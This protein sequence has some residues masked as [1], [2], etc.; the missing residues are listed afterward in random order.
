MGL[1]VGAVAVGVV[2]FGIEPPN[3]GFDASLGLPDDASLDPGGIGLRTLIMVPSGFLTFTILKAFCESE[4]LTVGATFV[5]A[6]GLAVAG[7]SVA[8]LGVAGTAVVD[9]SEAFA[10]ASRAV[11]EEAILS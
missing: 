11:S 2:A 1:R 10:S 7:L 6:A 8:G 4:A 9:P 5:V 3:A